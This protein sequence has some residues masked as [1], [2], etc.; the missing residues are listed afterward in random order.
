YYR[1]RWYDPQARRFISED[2]IGLNGGINLYA[3]VENNPLNRI[4]PEGT[5]PG[6]IHAFQ[7][8]A[9]SPHTQRAISAIQRYGRQATNAMQRWWQQGQNVANTCSAS[10]GKVAT[11][12]FDSFEAFKR[13]MGPAGQGL[14]WHH[15]VEQNPTNIAQFGQ[16]ALQ[17]TSNLVKLNTTLHYQISG[18]YSSIRPDVTGSTNLTVRQWISGQSFEAQMKFGQNIVYKILN[19][20]AP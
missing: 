16:Q 18:F 15:I 19:G 5:N 4:D 13:A 11:Q 10:S 3:Y 1:A 7:R 2:P 6:L 8:I 9:Q 14:Q 17:N 12:A 20:T